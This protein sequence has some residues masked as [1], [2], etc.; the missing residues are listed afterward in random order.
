M[1][2]PNSAIDTDLPSD[3]LE[4]RLQKN[5]LISLEELDRTDEFANIVAQV[6]GDDRRWIHFLDHPNAEEVVPEPWRQNNPD[7]SPE[8]LHLMKMIVINTLRPDRY[9]PASKMLFKMVFADESLSQGQINLDNIV[10]NGSNPKSPLLLVSAPGYDASYMVEQLGKSKRKKYTAVAIGSPE[11]FEESENAI[12]NAARSGSW[13]LLKNVHL[14]PQWLV[15]LEKT[16]YKLQLNPQFRLFLTMEVNPK[17][18]TTLLRASCVL[19]F[20]PPSGIKAA[21]T[22]SYKQT[23]SQ[24][25][26]DRKPV[27]RAKLHFITAWFNAVVQERLRYIPIGWSKAYEFNQS[28]QRCVITCI[29]EW[30]DSMGQGREV[31]DPDSIPWDALKA[32]VSQSIFGGKID[33]EFDLKILQSLVDY[34]FCKESFNMDYPLFES[35]DVDPNSR[36]TI[37]EHKQYAQF[38]DWIKQLPDVESPAWSGLPLNVEKLNRI[39]ESSRLM[40]NTK[41]IQGTE[42][43]EIQGAAQL[44]E[45]DG[46]AQWLVN[47]SKKVGAYL[48]MLPNQLDNMRRAESSVK[49]P[50]F[51]FI[52]RECSV[53]TSLLASVRTDFEHVIEVCSGEKKSTN[54]LKQVAQDLHSDVI[55]KSWKKYIVPLTMTASEW[56]LDFVKRVEQIKYVSTSN[57]LGREGIWFG[58]LQSPEAYL[59]ATQQST[60]QI[61]NWS[62]EQLELRFDFN[63]SEEEVNNAIDNK[64]GFIIK[65]LS[66]ESAEYDSEDN[67]IKLSS[68]LSSTLPT[69]NL[70][71]VHKEEQAKKN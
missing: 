65:G 16:I 70:Q 6:Q 49:N 45:K 23:I 53:L 54:H 28:D 19:I 35:M 27:Q 36:L 14:A 41:L 69:I 71:W 55:P 68:K 58:G 31:V 60:A 15:S 66:I 47:L 21:M 10:E 50:L 7:F 26:S 18:P 2:K 8:T 48:D 64:T 11:A 29:D 1:L 37:P 38:S 46:Q 24:E 34:F 40:M 56:L 17:V 57:L 42:D 61:N 5:Q 9:V 25:M 59:I 22:R 51:R 44:G 3:F 33:N 67:R 13:V 30:L 52:D 39:R 12:K 4:G 43:D 63:P 20:E 62:L 32:L